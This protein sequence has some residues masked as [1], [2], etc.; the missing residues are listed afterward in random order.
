LARKQ[1][2]K[3]YLDSHRPRTAIQLGIFLIVTRAWIT[4]FTGFENRRCNGSISSPTE[5]EGFE[6]HYPQA[7]RRVPPTSSDSCYFDVHVYFIVLIASINYCYLVSSLSYSTLI[8][9]GHEFPSSPE[10]KN[11]QKLKPESLIITYEVQRIR[12]IEQIWGITK[13]ASGSQQHDRKD[14]RLE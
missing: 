5:A 7:R 11:L 4:S 8:T 6:C 3:F 9:F 10:L 2:T 1:T 13:G 12:K 14:N